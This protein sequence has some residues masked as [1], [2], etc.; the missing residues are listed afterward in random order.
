MV[1]A[2]EGQGA[3][4]RSLLDLVDDL[5]AA[6]VALA[7]I[8][9]GV[10]V[11]RHRADGLEDRRPGE[12]LGGDE[13]DLPALPLELPPEQLR[14]L[15]VDLGKHRAAQMLKSLVRDGHGGDATGPRGCGQTRC[16]MWSRTS[17]ASIAPSRRIFGSRPVR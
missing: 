12:V 16:P 1:A 17:A 13:L 6:V 11:R 7:R 9:L 8:P 3:V 14:D 10:L 15:G 5:A 2:E 4:D